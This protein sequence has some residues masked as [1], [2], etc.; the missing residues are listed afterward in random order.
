MAWATNGSI[1]YAGGQNNK[2]H[3]F[4]ELGNHIGEMY[5]MPGDVYDIDVSPDGTMI[6]VPAAMVVAELST[7]QQVHW[8][9]TVEQ[10][11]Q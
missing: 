8:S 7:P 5:E 3:T 9:Q 6:V 4:D 11:H 10:F 1:F 2:V